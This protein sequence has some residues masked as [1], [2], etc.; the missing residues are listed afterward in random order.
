MFLVAMFIVDLES[1][2]LA[3]SSYQH[4][5]GFGEFDSSLDVLLY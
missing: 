3:H 5:T 2:E 1:A 4:F